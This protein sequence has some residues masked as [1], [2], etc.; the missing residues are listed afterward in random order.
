MTNPIM[1]AGDQGARLT[2]DARA[3]Y[4][5]SLFAR[6]VPR[7]DLFNSLSTFGQD[8]RWR[9]MVVDLAAVPPGGRALDVATGTG[10]VAFAMAARAPLAQVEGLDFCAPMIVAAREYA[11]T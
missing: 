3:E 4:V 2:G 11:R 1:L 6:I 10:A 7:Y 9:R 5:R 8:R